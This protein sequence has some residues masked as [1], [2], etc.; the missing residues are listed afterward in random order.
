MLEHR[1]GNA[2]FE[3]TNTFVAHKNWCRLRYWCQQGKYQN[4]PPPKR[5]FV[6]REWVSAK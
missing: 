3:M 6:A 4:M 5:H 1:V 2:G